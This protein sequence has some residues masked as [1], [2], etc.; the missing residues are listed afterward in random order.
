MND[1]DPEHERLAE[2]ERL[3]AEQ[4]RQAQENEQRYVEQTGRPL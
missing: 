3:I 1:H 4:D 2:V